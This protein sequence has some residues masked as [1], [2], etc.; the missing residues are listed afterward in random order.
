MP[1]EAVVTPEPSNHVL[2]VDDD[3]GVRF[4]LRETL[5]S[6]EGVSVDVAEDGEAAL[7]MLAARPYELV[8][9]DLRMPR[10][11]GL[12]LV[13]RLQGMPRTPRVI[14][15]TAHGSERFAV[16]AMKAGAY[17][18]FRKP[19]DVD[20]LLA[21]V[22]RALEAVR[23]RDENERLAGELNLSRSLVFASEAMRR[24][25]QLVQ[26]A[27][28][29]DVTVLITGESGTGKERVAE[30]LVRASPR[31]KGP[32]LRFNCAALTEELAEAELFGHS[33]G[34]FTGANRVRPGLFREADGGTLLL[35]EV[36][37]L[38]PPLQAKLLRVLQEGEVR[39]VGEDRPVKVDVRIIAATHRDLRRRAAEGAFRED[40]YYRLNVVQLRV[41]PLRERPEDIPVLARMFLDRF[42]DRFH[43]GPLKVP[44]D[45]F[46]RLRAL[47]WPGNVRE[48]ENTLESLVALSSE[49]ELDLGLLPVP[50]AP[51]GGEGGGPAVVAPASGIEPRDDLPGAGLK[52]R[53][54]A[55]E[56]GLILDALRIAGGNRSE[57]A[58][59]LGIGRATLH[60][61]L[62]KYGLDGAPDEGA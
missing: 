47:P 37:E 34:A 39:P 61:K 60:D 4:T 43:T 14:V 56:R 19:F 29:R 31:A 58:R 50:D 17:D 21:V 25:A 62:R 22:S 18:Y 52:E 40:L 30:A 15:V 27:G 53:V 13:K 6:L 54:E 7:R 44:E 59:R 8:I 16:E 28:S 26:R 3:A 35:D 32:Y 42:S 55:Y 23:L 38:A 46:D 24:L 45:F 33:K 1:G 49:G 51:A 57:A 41:P 11:D 5:R 36:G 10:L 48:L 9:T 12:E 2:V 20:E